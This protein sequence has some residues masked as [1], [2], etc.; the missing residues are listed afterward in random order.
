[1]NK[2]YCFLFLSILILFLT[3][4]SFSQDQ[5]ANGYI[6]PEGLG[7]SNQMKYSYDNNLKQEI[8]EDW[9]NADYTKGIF[10]AGFRFDTFQP[11]DPNPA[12]YRGKKRFADIDY[13]YVKLE[14]G[15]VEEGAELTVGNFYEL[16]GRGMILKSYEDRNI[17]IDNNLLGVKVAGKYKGFILTALT[18]MPEN[19]DA[20]RT[21][22]LHAADLEYDGLNFLKLGSSFASNQPNADG[23]ART[24]LT[25]FRV[26]PSFW[27]IDIYSEYGIKQNDNIRETVFNG[28]RS[29]AGRAFYGN[30]N[31]FLS[32][33]AF[34]GEY[35]YY[36]NF[37][38][39]SYDGTVNYNTPPAV[40]K[41]Y[42]YSLLNR[43]PSPLNPSNEQGF[44]TEL[45]YNLDEATYL[46]GYYGKTRTLP[47]SSFYQRVIGTN[48]PVRDQ[49]EEGYIQAQHDWGEKMTTI[50][51]FGYYKELDSDTKSV[52]PILENRFYF[53]EINTIKLTIEHQQ[54]TVNTTSEMYYD[55]EVTLEYYRSPKFYLSLVSEMQTREPEPGRTLRKFWNFF[56]VGYKIGNHTD[57]SLLIGS[58]Q[59]GNICIGGVCRYEPEF[60][61]VELRMFTRF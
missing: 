58:R 21:D 22:I 56:Q 10:S 16:F 33:L 39:N 1:M 42:T 32:S 37:S 41:E 31:F 4:N 19:S 11:N 23:L 55:D 57:I 15:D 51:A 36:D 5:P 2:L 30:L 60:H 6:L 27:N 38:F 50:A 18:G 47:P 25:S 46:I 54:T 43:H 28:S 29:I 40:R 9:F 49:L 26:E 48:V 14:V 35:K 3:K 13:K 20:N 59:A 45:D 17:R 8:F 7:L 34:S 52:T 61:G 12:I 44:G 24:R 53:D